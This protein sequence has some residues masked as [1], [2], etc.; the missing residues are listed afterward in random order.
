MPNVEVRD[1]ARAIVETED[2]RKPLV[3]RFFARLRALVPRMK[4]QGVVLLAG[5]DYRQEPGA[6][7]HEELELLVKS[8]LTPAEALAAATIEPARF[9]G[10]ADKLGSVRPGLEAD[11]VLLQG[12]P[13]ADI[14]NSRRIV[15][16]IRAG[17]LFDARQLAELRKPDGEAS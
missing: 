12:N 7:L 2:E 16:V 11:L 1:F 6:T 14:R 5:T 10:L 9:L 13:L 17:R 3:E 8:G 4:A 15:A